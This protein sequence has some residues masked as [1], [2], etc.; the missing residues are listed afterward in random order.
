[1][2]NF[3]FRLILLMVLCPIFNVVSLF[4]QFAFNTKHTI[5]CIM[6]CVIG[7]IYI[8]IMSTIKG[9]ESVRINKA[10]LIYSTVIKY[11]FLT[12]ATFEHTFEGARAYVGYGIVGYFLNYT[13]PTL[14]FLIEMIAFY[15]K[16]NSKT[17][18]YFV[19]ASFLCIFLTLTQGVESFWV[20]FMA[21]PFMTL[22]ITFDNTKLVIIVAIITNII[23]LVGVYRQLDLDDRAADPLMRGVYVMETC[24][25]ILFTLAIVYSTILIK[26]INQNKLDVIESEKN[27]IKKLSNKM[28]DIG[29][30]VKY[31]SSKTMDLVSDLNKSTNNTL[32][33]L[34]EI[35]SGNTTNINSVEEQYEMSVNITNLIKE[36]FEEINSMIKA[37]KESIIGLQHTKKSYE[38]LQSKSN[39]IV[40]KNKNVTKTL[41]EFILNVRRVKDIINGIYNISEETNLLALNASIE[42]ARVGDESKGFALV[43]SEIKNLAESST[44]LID[45]I[46]RI[47][48]KLEFNALKTKEEVC[49][50]V[51][52][53]D[54][55]YVTIHNIKQEFKQMKNRVA[56][57]RQNVLSVLDK[58]KSIMNLNTKIERHVASLAASD[59]E[60]TACTEE[61]VTLGK[62]NQTKTYETKTLMDELAEEVNKLD[63]YL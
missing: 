1:M 3:K 48:R 43:S 57:L 33:A 24:F 18:K 16:P 49:K 2:N 21:I 60:V 15:K 36:V 50:V 51:N 14:L 40:E 62:D 27:K 37:T 61:V 12:G 32:L 11:I 39:S 17:I 20:G 4:I 34:Q 9:D 41:D 19:I 54:E 8:S 23:N 31:N 38:I 56:I 46:E 35:K 59:E 52:E 7:I 29:I 30:K 22:Y 47:V 28:I 26:K 25:I 45:D 63:K 10:L 42:S 53:I 13:I 44:I 58:V 5:P 55:E 6:F